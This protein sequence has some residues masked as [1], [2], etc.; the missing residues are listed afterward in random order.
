MRRTAPWLAAAAMVALLLPG[1]SDHGVWDPWEL[2]VAEQARA[3]AEGAAP[4]TPPTTAVVVA[5]AG[6]RLLGVHGWAGRLP[7]ALCG[8]LLLASIA[9]L[10]ARLVGRRAALYAALC[11]C[12]TPAFLLNTRTLLGAA[13]EL[14]AHGLAGL[15]GALYLLPGPRSRTRRRMW[16]LAG[17]CAGGLSVL[18]SGVLRGA[19]PVLWAL[20]GTA[21][22]A[23][24]PARGNEGPDAVELN[25]GVPGRPAI[26]TLGLLTLLLTAAV[27]AV[28]ARDGAGPSPWTGGA[29]QGVTPPTFDAPLQA[30]FHGLAPF[31]ALLPIAIAAAVTSGAARPAVHT[32]LLLWA[33]GGY[34]AQL[35]FLARYGD[36]AA[37]LPLTAL[38][39]VLGSTLRS[40]EQREETSWPAAV[41]LALG[42]LLLVRDYAIFPEGP[43]ASLAVAGVEL[44]KGFDM[45][46]PW[47][48]LLALFTLVGIGVL[49]AGGAQRKPPSPRAMGA[50]IG[51][52]WRSSVGS[53][54]WLSLAALALLALVALGIAAFVA[55]DRLGLNALA[56]RWLRRGTFTPLL[57]VGVALGW[58]LALWALSRL[59]TL[60][61][62]A[63]VVA[64]LLVGGFTS[65]RFLPRLSAQLSPRPAYETYEALSGGGEPLAAYG[66]GGGSAA[67]YAPNSI[68][69]LSRM[70][71]L[72]DHLAAKERHWAVLPAD[73][74]AELDRAYRA[75]TGSHVFVVDARSPKVI[76]AA[77]QPIPRRHNQNFLE[78]AVLDAPPDKIDHPT[79]VRFGHAIELLGYDMQLPH[80]DHVGAGE[81]LSLV[82]YYRVL[83]SV[84]GDYQPF[85]HIDGPDRVNGD[86]QPVG[87]KYPVRLWRKGDIIADKHRIKVPATTAA[88]DYRIYTGF[89]RGETRLPVE[90][91]DKDPKRRAKVGVL[92]IR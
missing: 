29:P 23:P 61:G 45:R 27:V 16:L 19:L 88:G 15:C 84:G 74:L 36:A 10:G 67:Y 5:S 9:L 60:R 13:P 78:K 11:L 87:G 80:G 55:P 70:A 25:D 57:L 1:L 41:A 37:Y 20:V 8:L 68:I 59:G 39:L 34:A 64:G 3:L 18:A 82:W 63:M 30:L 33:S 62:V 31:S 28:V 69:A 90:L 83:R 24:G 48:A 79:Q 44:P 40:L 14:L 65:H 50:A 43:L 54:L 26:V 75:R 6:F 86:H 17:L 32:W 73:K 49:G 58:P 47:A 52:Q 81:Y 21:W 56:T 12:C 22:L 38:A 51:Q 92:R 46:A 35:L 71:E 53:R 4:A 66:L 7:A 42:G 89:F 76:L 91:G 77:S 72:V 2:R 85:V